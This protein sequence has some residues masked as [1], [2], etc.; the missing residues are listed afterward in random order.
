MVTKNIWGVV[1]SFAPFTHNEPK[2]SKSH[3]YEPIPADLITD[4]F[5][6]EPEQNERNESVLA[7]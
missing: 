4:F 5:I 7:G 1:E 6:G 2:L 3:A